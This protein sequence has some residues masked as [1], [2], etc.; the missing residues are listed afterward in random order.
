MKQFQAVGVIVMALGGCTWVDLNES[1]QAVQIGYAGNVQNCERLGVV[2]ASTRSAL[3]MDRDVATVQEELYVLA[4]N[5]A[6][7]MG[8]TNLVQHA[9]P[10][11]GVQNFTAYRCPP[12]NT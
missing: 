3:V 7:T 2:T 12:T 10:D 8:A 5:N 4:R 9:R 11:A 6:A 1:G